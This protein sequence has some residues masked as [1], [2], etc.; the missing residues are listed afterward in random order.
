M[1][2][3]AFKVEFPLE[4]APTYPTKLSGG[5]V[6]RRIVAAFST[7]VA[8]EHAAH[9][10]LDNLIRLV[11]RVDSQPPAGASQQR[12]LSLLPPKNK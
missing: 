6:K 2:S 5:A 4:E 11:R 10:A 12:M 1:V 8:A 9:K 7:Q 3:T